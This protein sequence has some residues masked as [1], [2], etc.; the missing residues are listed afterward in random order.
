MPACPLP[1]PHASASSSKPPHP[2]DE[3]MP[4]RSLLMIACLALVPAQAL[5]RAGHP[6]AR[7]NGDRERRDLGMGTAR[8]GQARPRDRPLSPHRRG[9]EA[10]GARRTLR[11][12]AAGRGPARAGPRRGPGRARRDP[13]GAR[14]Q[15]RR[16]AADARHQ[17]RGRADLPR[18]RRLGQANESAPRPRL[19]DPG[20]DAASAGDGGHIRPA[21]PAQRRRPR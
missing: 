15:R 16:A 14:L 4:N 2:K 5:A 11:P 20:R 10:G 18:A 21:R 7:G 8:P 13:G 6:A 3:A 9:S 12:G 17:Q 19:L 1:R